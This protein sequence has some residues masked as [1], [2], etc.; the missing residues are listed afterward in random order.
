MTR[1]LERVSHPVRTVS[2]LTVRARIPVGRGSHIRRMLADDRPRPLEAVL[3][4]GAP[5]LVRQAWPAST[6]DV[7]STDV[8][9]PE[10]TVLSD[11]LGADSL[12]HSRWSRVV[13]LD[14]VIDEYLPARLSA[15]QAACEPGGVVIVIERLSRPVTSVLE[16]ETARTGL[17]L[18]TERRRHGVRLL[19]LRRSS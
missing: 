2:R 3:V 1:L 5:V 6:I 9:D 8:R 17:Y 16:W 12:P 13:I 14:P 10:L 7:M 11:G 19:R 4:A 18:E 15:L